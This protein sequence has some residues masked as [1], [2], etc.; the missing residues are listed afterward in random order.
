MNWEHV[1]E[2]RDILA[3]WTKNQ[4]LPITVR[5]PRADVPTGRPLHDDEWVEIREL[6]DSAIPQNI[7]RRHKRILRLL[8]QAEEQ[9]AAPTLDDLAAALEVGK[10]TIKR[11]LAALRQAG[12][13]INTRGSREG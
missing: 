8:H 1:P 3:A 11:N 7:A 5:L 9:D 6:E 10:A 2:H 12:H 4:P 13:T